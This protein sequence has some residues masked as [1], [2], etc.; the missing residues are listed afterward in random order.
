[1][2]QFT[3]FFV[4]LPRSYGPLLTSNFNSFIYHDGYHAVTTFFVDLW[5]SKRTRQFGHIS[6][7]VSLLIYISP[8]EKSRDDGTVPSFFF[9]SFFGVLMIKP[10]VDLFK[11]SMIGIY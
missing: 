9:L 6:F 7:F 4:Y 2:D 11:A 3:H 8:I 1:M 10:F 5:P